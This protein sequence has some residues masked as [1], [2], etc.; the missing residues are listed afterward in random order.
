MSLFRPL[1]ASALLPLLSLFPI[2]G[3]S[4][5][6]VMPRFTS[7][8]AL[9][10]SAAERFLDAQEKGNWTMLYAFMPAVLQA[11]Y[12]SPG[13]LMRFVESPT[14]A[15]LQECDLPGMETETIASA[16]SVKLLIVVR[17]EGPEKKAVIYHMIMLLEDKSWK[18]LYCNP[19]GL[20]DSC[21]TF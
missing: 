20:E 11:K 7:A 9:C 18:V 4:Q 16:R 8:D 1:A 10:P 21:E 2:R 13:E 19:S 6:A 14:K 3:F 12:S 17:H 5:G 15:Y